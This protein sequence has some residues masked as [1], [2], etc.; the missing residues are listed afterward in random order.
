[1]TPSAGVILTWSNGS[2]DVKSVYRKLDDF[3]L[4]RTSEFGW[5]QGAKP[6]RIVPH[7]QVSALMIVL[8]SS[9]EERRYIR[10][11]IRIQSAQ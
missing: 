5:T 2:V 9:T 6:A 3:G 1:V 11:A 8:G 7:A 4:A 10:Y